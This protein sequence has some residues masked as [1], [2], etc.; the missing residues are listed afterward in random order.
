MEVFGDQTQAILRAVDEVVG[1]DA[2]T[3]DPL[4]D[5]GDLDRCQVLLEGGA[6]ILR[7]AT[8]TYLGA[9]VAAASRRS[10]S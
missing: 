6:K 3:G 1:V 4:Q 10:F 7:K 8:A 9:P 2:D 5:V